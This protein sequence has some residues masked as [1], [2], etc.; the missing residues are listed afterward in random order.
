MAELG[1]FN[2]EERYAELARRVSRRDPGLSFEEYSDFV[3][4]AVYRMSTVRYTPQY[5]GSI[6][7]AIEFLTRRW[8]DH[9]V[10]PGFIDSADRL[11][12]ALEDSGKAIRA[13][14]AIE[15]LEDFA[16]NTGDYGAAKHF[17]D[18]GLRIYSE[19]LSPDEREICE[20]LHE[21]MEIDLK[22]VGRRL[23]P[24]TSGPGEKLSP[25]SVSAIKSELGR[26]TDTANAFI[27]AFVENEELTG[28]ED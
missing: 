17:L 23:R 11:L 6:L 16:F 28:L 26:L 7:L 14:D 15:L 9:A 24:A 8:K 3:F 5:Q 2:L 21:S 12:K 1:P 20:R 10:A 25:E 4:L 13:F 22:F 19:L 18:R 27:E